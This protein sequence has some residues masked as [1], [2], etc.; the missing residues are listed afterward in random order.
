[1]ASFQ[2]IDISINGVSYPDAYGRHVGKP[3]WRESIIVIEREGGEIAHLEAIPLDS[4]VDV[5]DTG[6]P[7]TFSGEYQ[8][9]GGNYR[10]Y[11]F[12]LSNQKI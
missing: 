9:I 4:V 12:R 2:K 7:G 5:Q 3:E 6:L 10:Q 11:I 1:M 8:Y